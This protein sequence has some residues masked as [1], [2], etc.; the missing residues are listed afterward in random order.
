MAADVVHTLNFLV[1]LAV[2]GLACMFVSTFRS[3]ISAGHVPGEGSPIGE[4]PLMCYL[5][6]GIRLS[7]PQEPRYSAL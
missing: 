6:R 1:Y 2:D 5:L 3:A 7:L 4:H